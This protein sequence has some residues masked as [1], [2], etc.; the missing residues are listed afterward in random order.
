[1]EKTRKNISETKLIYGAIACMFLFLMCEELFSLEWPGQSGSAIKNFAQNDQ[2][3]PSRGIVFLQDESIYPI[4]T[5]ELLFMNTGNSHS[6]FP[7]PLGN[8]IAIQHQDELISI[9]SHLSDFDPSSIPEIVDKQLP[10]AKS[11]LS[12][13][14]S[15]PALQFSVFDRKTFGY[16]NPQLLINTPDTEAPFIRQT[17][18]TGSDNQKILLGQTRSIRQG[19]YR[20]FVDA[21][22]RGSFF[23]NNQVAPYQISLYVNGA[24]E[25]QLDLDLLRSKSG[26]L[27]V[28]L[29]N[30][31]NIEKIYQRD[32][33]YLVAE[34]QLNRGKFLCEVIVVD[35][36]GNQKSQT[37]QILVE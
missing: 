30:G 32:G 29:R 13:W 12:G 34:I 31:Q 23:G 3:A 18:L 26:L 6:S 21:F 20:F 25:G 11:G 28:S 9:Y 24:L 1:M 17:I 8:W 2:A 37:Y 27:Q 16:V 35:A 33:S 22:D 5:G 10:L 36:A 4:D 15:S 19:T 14:T 7:A